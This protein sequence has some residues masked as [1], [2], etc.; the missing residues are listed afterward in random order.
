VGVV[1]CISGLVAFIQFTRVQH[2]MVRIFV[3]VMSL[4]VALFG[5]VNGMA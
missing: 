5:V 1:D 3:L 4:V 2:T